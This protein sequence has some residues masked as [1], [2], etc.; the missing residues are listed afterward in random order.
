MP[1]QPL[2]NEHTEEIPQKGQ[3]AFETEIYETLRLVIHDLMERGYNPYHIAF[4]LQK[5]RWETLDAVRHVRESNSG[6]LP[7]A[8]AAY[9]FVVMYPPP[10]EQLP[11]VTEWLQGTQLES[12]DHP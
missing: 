1:N 7:K 12:E 11:L 2:R 6:I 5:V 10:L 9:T 8:L 3:S 4:Q